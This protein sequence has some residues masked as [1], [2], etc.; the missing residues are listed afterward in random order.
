MV[1]IEAKPPSGNLRALLRR[2]GTASGCLLGASRW[3]RALERPTLASP[4]RPPQDRGL[5]R[6]ATSTKSALVA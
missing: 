1:T 6:I 3:R 2:K 4:A 5:A